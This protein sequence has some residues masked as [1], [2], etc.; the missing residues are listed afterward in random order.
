M[1]NKRHNGPRTVLLAALAALVAG[2]GAA[3][4]AP[5]AAP[6]ANSSPGAASAQ[7]LRT[8]TLALDWTP[9][10]NHTGIFVAQQRGWYREQGLE[11][12]ILPNSEGSATDPLVS[13]GKADF[14]ISFEESVVLA[15]AAGQDVVSVAAIIQ[16]NTSALVARKDAGI[17]RPRQLEGKLYAGY[18]APFEE[19]VISTVIKSDGG[20]GRY[21]TVTANAGAYEALKARRADFAWLFMGVDGVRAQREGFGLNAFYIKDHGVPDYYTPVIV[22]S[23]K[24][25]AQDP[26]TVRRFMAA[27]ARGYEY[28]IQSPKEAAALLVQGAPNEAALDPAFTEASQQWISP[29]YKEGQESWGTQE[30]RVWTEYPRFMYSTG[31]VVDAAG[32]PVKEEPRY[33]EYFTNEFLPQG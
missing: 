1:G 31:K 29:R 11:L 4:T 25:I 16:S 33:E 26:D 2:C 9:N 15:R 32:K 20:R 23:R 27:T 24:R 14:G 18:G 22:T 8:V 3:T 6:G 28:A 12:K 7:P 13:A 30:L 10:T 17:T 5:G 21:R 19:A